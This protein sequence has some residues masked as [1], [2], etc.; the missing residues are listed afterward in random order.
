MNIFLGSRPLLM[1]Q[2]GKGKQKKYFIFGLTSTKNLGDSEF[3]FQDSF[4]GLGLLFSKKIDQIC[5]VE[6]L[7]FLKWAFGTPTL[8]CLVRSLST[9]WILDALSPVFHAIFLLPCY[10]LSCLF[11]ST[12]YP[13]ESPH[14]M[15]E[16]NQI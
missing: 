7:L 15:S 12:A 6:L 4:F 11:F 1:G 9:V 8:K 2:S 3:C 14:T 5:I 10:A 16:S 13:S